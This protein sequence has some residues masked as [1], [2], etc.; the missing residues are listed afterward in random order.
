MELSGHQEGVGA[1]LEEGARM[2]SE[3]VLSGEESDEVRLQM[4][5]LNSRWEALRINS[6]E[7]QAKYEL[8][9]LKFL[10]N[11]FFVLFHF[12]LFY[13]FL[14]APF[15]IY[16]TTVGSINFFPVI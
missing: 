13:F 6:M 11:Q 3:G 16:F 8:F 14:F 9:I 10:T 2:L 1:V 5:L 15:Y 7:K 4:K 12:I